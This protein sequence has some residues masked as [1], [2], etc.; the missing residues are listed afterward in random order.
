[1]I[2]AN[3][4]K[5]LAGGLLTVSIKDRQGNVTKIERAIRIDL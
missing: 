2:L 3:P 1:M 5:K 4:V